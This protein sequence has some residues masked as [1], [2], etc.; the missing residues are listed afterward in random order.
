MTGTS[1]GGL[2]AQP[3]Y[4]RFVS[5]MTDERGVI[6]APMLRYP[7][8]AALEVQRHRLVKAL[9]DAR[10][11]SGR[12]QM[13][14]AQYI[15]ARAT[16]LRE[17]TEPPAAPP[18][19]ATLDASIQRRAR[20]VQA[21]EQALLALA[22]DICQAVREHPAYEQDGR[23]HISALHEH[24]A[25]KRREAAEAERE[26]DAAGSFVQWLARAAADELYVAT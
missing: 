15:A 9:A 25:Q 2:V 14:D 1:T 5:D 11:P 20:D 6:P 18:T 4:R 22:D 10:R 12:P 7:E 19:Q 26:A 24:A 23:R 21:V 3:A 16:A 13:S 8:L 17:G